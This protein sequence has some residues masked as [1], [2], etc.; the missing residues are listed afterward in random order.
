MLVNKSDYNNSLFADSPKYLIKDLR[1]V[2]NCAINFMYNFK[3][4][5]H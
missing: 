1:F 2:V 4:S 5:E 3:M